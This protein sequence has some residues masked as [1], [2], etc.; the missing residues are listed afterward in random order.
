MANYE[1]TEL[2]DDNPEYTAFCEKFK[3]KKTTD[4]CY[5]PPYIYDAV[6]NWAVSEYGLE[7][8][9]VV[10]PFYPGGDYEHYTYPKNCVVVDNPP[11][12][13]LAQILDY[14]TE[15]QIDYFL[16]APALTVISS[17]AA[18]NANAVITSSNVIYENGANVKTAFVTNLGEYKI[19]VSSELH[20]AIKQAQET[21]KKE[22]ARTLP[23]YSYPNEVLTAATIQKIAEHGETLRIKPVEC[24]F[25]RA[26]D[27]QKFK[28]KAL[29]GGGFLLSEKAAAEKA[30]AEKA[31]AEKAAAEKAA[32]EKAAAE[33]AAAETWVLSD[34]EIEI[35]RGLGHAYG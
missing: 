5:T 14:Y 28:G 27:S 21:A 8:R 18:R 24:Y 3:Q 19:H 32:A 7:G 10:R 20:D 25:V 13:I 2:F 17:C 4:D 22:N 30:A 34:R 1:Q 16:F 11:F 33:K 35:V 23:K 15:R 31:A 29:F 9:P 6:L 26:L 12:S